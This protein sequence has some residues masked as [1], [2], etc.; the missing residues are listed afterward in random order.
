MSTSKEFELGPGFKVST[1]PV[2]LAE[3]ETAM[4]M[5]EEWI[6][7]TGGFLALTYRA[8]Q[9]KAQ[10]AFEELFCLACGLSIDEIRKNVRVDFQDNIVACINCFLGLDIAD[11][12]LSRGAKKVTA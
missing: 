2:T 6:N 12:I 5:Y 7:A 9:E 3:L 11:E 8:G 4:K 1:K 10:E